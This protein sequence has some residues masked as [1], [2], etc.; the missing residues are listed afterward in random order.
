MA[1]HY[2]S[3]FF[4]MYEII[5]NRENKS[6]KKITQI[7]KAP[8]SPTSSFKDLVYE[9]WQHQTAVLC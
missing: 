2:I 6:V 4:C 9:E 3:T 1:V 5:H 7:E 8:K